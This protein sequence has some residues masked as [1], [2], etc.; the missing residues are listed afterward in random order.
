[1]FCSNCGK[2]VEEGAQFCVSCGA[3]LGQKPA[4]EI[5]VQQDATEV[6][7]QQVVPEASV[8][9]P[10]PG[11]VPQQPS[12]AE[13]MLKSLLAIIKGLFSKNIVRTV[14]EQAK[15]TGNEWIFGIILSLL[16]FTMAFSVNVLQGTKQF[17][18]SVAGGLLGDGVMEYIKFPFGPIL[19]MSFLIGIVVVAFVIVGIRVMATL[20]AK[21]KVSWICVLNLVGS[22][23][24]PLSFCYIVNMILGIIWIPLPIIVSIVALP[25][26]IV[27][28]YVG[29]QKLEK[30]VV[31][32]FYPFT[33]IVAIVVTIALLLFFVLFK[34]ILADWM[35]SILGSGLN[36][37]G[38]FF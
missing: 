33:I 12:A 34:S 32:P 11:V 28:L 3:N 6:P 17:I 26:T 29:S 2:K 36:M 15:N 9:Q 7:V 25:M 5:V 10:V 30:P 37:L 4:P 24:I 1:M 27:L 8:Q 20:V 19:G 18:K 16:S 13:V 21:K 31:S 23:T 38:S 22:A 14:G 35:G